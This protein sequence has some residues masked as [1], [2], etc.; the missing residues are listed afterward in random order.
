MNYNNYIGVIFSSVSEEFIQKILSQMSKSQLETG[1]EYFY[2]FSNNSRVK[3]LMIDFYFKDV[4]FGDLST[5]NEIA[6][7]QNIDY[8]I[9]SKEFSK[10]K[11]LKGK[12]IVVPSE[13]SFYFD[14]N[15]EVISNFV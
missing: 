13:E 8:I 2:I 4:A 1:K 12:S 5:E 3:N 9:S 6:L 15:P 11:S 10:D 7:L 14:F